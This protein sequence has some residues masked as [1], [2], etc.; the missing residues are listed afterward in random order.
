MD[1]EGNILML[2]GKLNPVWKY[3]DSKTFL[4]IGAGDINNDGVKEIVGGSSSGELYALSNKGKV[5]W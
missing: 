5:I 1:K 4:A 3:D 2:D